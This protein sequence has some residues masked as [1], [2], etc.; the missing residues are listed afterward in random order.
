MLPHSTQSAEFTLAIPDNI[1]ITATTKSGAS[2]GAELVAEAGVRWA[3]HPRTTLDLYVD[4]HREFQAIFQ[5]MNSLGFTA[6]P[7]WR[8]NYPANTKRDSVPVTFDPPKSLQEQ[9]DHVT[10]ELAVGRGQVLAKW[11]LVYTPHNLQERLRAL[12]GDGRQE[13]NFAFP[14]QDLLDREGTPRPDLVLPTLKQMWDRA[15]A[16]S[17]PDRTGLLRGSS[18]PPAGAD[19]LL[20][21]AEHGLSTAAGELLRPEPDNSAK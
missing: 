20:R 12:A 18:A 13:V 7:G 3:V 1:L 8:T 19:V 17:D 14:R 9:V 10:I 4:P 21:A 5:A 2:Q 15:L 11:I 16:E 6:K